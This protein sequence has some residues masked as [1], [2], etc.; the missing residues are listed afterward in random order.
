MDTTKAL[1]L[2]GETEFLT[3]PAETAQVLILTEESVLVW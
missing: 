1:H 3:L 2:H